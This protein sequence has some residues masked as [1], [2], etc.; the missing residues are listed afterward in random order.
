MLDALALDQLQPLGL[1]TVDPDEIHLVRGKREVKRTA[2]G[3]AGAGVLGRLAGEL[4]AQLPVDRPVC[5]L[6]LGG[7]VPS[8]LASVAKLCARVET[9]GAEELGCVKVLVPR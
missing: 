2:V 7:A 8:L 4:F 5:P 3:R 6:T 1:G 9:H